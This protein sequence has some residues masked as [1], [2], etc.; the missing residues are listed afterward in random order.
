MYQT[1]TFW[2]HIHDDGFDLSSDSPDQ[3]TT[4]SENN[5]RECY[6]PDIK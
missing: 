3:S 4:P 1:F 5:N 2:S 6:R